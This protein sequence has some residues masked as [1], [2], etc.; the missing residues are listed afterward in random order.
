VYDALDCAPDDRVQCAIVTIGLHNDQVSAHF[1]RISN[2]RLDDF[3]VT[4]LQIG[5]IRISRRALSPNVQRGDLW[6]DDLERSAT[7]GH[8]AISQKSER[9]LMLRMQSKGYPVS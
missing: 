5:K 3:T 7:A 6:F 9:S 2:Y 8:A 1:S 4:D